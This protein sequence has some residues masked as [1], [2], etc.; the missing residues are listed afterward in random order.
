[1]VLEDGFADKGAGSDDVAV[2]EDDALFR[3][4]DETRGL[5]TRM[6]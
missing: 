2:G 6:N 1:V 4:D 5:E 3:V